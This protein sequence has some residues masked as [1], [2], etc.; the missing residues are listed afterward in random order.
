VPR[1]TVVCVGFLW[2]CSGT[3]ICGIFVGLARGLRRV[4][5]TKYDLLGLEHNTAARW[6]Y[7]AGG[8]WPRNAAS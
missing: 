8:D 6:M 3:R 5:G 1:N 4:H 2:G 7:Q